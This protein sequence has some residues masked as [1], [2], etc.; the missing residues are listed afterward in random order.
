MKR[1]QI[2]KAIKRNMSTN[3]PMLIESSPGLGKTS[4]IEQL[5]AETGRKLF[6]LILSMRQPVDLVGLPVPNLKELTVVWLQSGFLPPS[7]YEQECTLFIDELANCSGMMQTAA[8]SLIHERRIGSYNLPKQCAIVA[9]TNR[10]SDKAGSNQIITSMRSRF[11]CYT[12]QADLN[13]LLEH[14]L[15]EKWHPYVIAYLRKNPDNLHFFDP[16]NIQENFPCPRTWEMVSKIEEYNEQVES[17]EVQD[18]IEE[19]ASAIGNT[20]A[21]EYVGFRRVFNDIPDPALIM[22]DPENAP[23]PEQSRPDVCFALSAALGKL[24]TSEN[25]GRIIQYLKRWTEEYNVLTMQDVFRRNKNSDEYKNIVNTQA[26]CNW[27]AENQ[28]VMV[29]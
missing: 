12:M 3:L 8:L 22:L 1:S 26:V 11:K 5:H 18:E 25:V 27:I 6:S 2:Q 20:I 29:G 17:I 16:R 14:A 9:A 4:L 10:A 28:S 24:A 7:D 13:D 23:L 19:F 21:L 15:Q